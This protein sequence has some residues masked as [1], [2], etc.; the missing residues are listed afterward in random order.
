[1]HGRAD[2]TPARDNTG[3]AR[4]SMGQAGMA[5]CGIAEAGRGELESGRR[6]VTVGMRSPV[7]CFARIY[8]TWCHLFSLS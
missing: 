2:A 6:C 1:M 5:E 3:L 4:A 8:P 7:G